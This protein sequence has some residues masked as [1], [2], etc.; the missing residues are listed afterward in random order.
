[1]RHSKV[2][3][4]FRSNVAQPVAEAV[5]PTEWRRIGA[6]FFASNAFGVL[7]ALRGVL[8]S[9][10]SVVSWPAFLFLSG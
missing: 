7:A 8:G 5:R 10:A 3:F 1:M 9:I 6:L 4:Q 2:G